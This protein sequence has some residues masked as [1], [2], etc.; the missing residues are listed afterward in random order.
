MNILVSK[1]F[2]IITVYSFLVKLDILFLLNTRKGMGCDQSRL[3]TKRNTR[4]FDSSILM[5]PSQV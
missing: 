4:V 3:E 1:G 2:W 5:F